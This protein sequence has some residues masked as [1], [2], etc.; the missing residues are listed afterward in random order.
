VNKKGFT[1]IEIMLVVAIIGILAAMLVP[2]LTG[3]T[4]QAKSAV[5]RADVD[6]NLALALDLYELDIGEFPPDLSYL[7]DNKNGSNSWRGPYLKK[8][9]KDPW[10]N[11]YVYQN[12]GNHSHRGYDLYSIGP[13]GQA[14]TGDD[15]ENWEE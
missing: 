7:S 13:D 1:L 10:G 6:V 15:V 14:R 5:A 2:R 12:P 9:P 11:E 8:L 3:R 4:R